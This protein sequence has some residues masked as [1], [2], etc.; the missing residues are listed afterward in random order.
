M[1]VAEAGKAVAGGTFKDVALRPAPKN[2]VDI[3]KNQFFESLA[4]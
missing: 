2:V 4:C 1:Y 3:N